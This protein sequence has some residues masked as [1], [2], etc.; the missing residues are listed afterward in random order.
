MPRTMFVFYFIFLH[1]LLSVVEKVLQSLHVYRQFSPTIET[2]FL[3]SKINLYIQFFRIL[4][5]KNIK[6]KN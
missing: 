3:I 1:N 2:I 6:N 5:Y 4:Y